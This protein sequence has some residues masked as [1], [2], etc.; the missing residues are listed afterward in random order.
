[1]LISI[2]R[3]DRYLSVSDIVSYICE[4][5]AF[6]KYFEIIEE[7]ITYTIP[8]STD[9]E[10]K[11]GALEFTLS[12]M[13][14]SYNIHSNMFTEQ[15]LSNQFHKTLFKYLKREIKEIQQQYNELKNGKIDEQNVV[16]ASNELV[17]QHEEKENKQNEIE[18]MQKD[19]KELNK[20]TNTSSASQA[21]SCN[22]TTGALNSKLN[23]DFTISSAGNG[24]AQK[25]MQSDP[26]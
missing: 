13:T 4:F 12:V 25:N 9:M 8:S 10:C 19:R 1:M 23:T 16:S 24:V 7:R 21:K 18:E 2:A 11:I 14:V 20:Q 17:I 22:E 6:D 5:E 15:L 3:A 26:I